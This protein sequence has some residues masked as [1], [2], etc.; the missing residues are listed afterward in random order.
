MK[1]FPAVDIKGGKVVRLLRGDYG[2][3]TVYG[4]DPV[5]AA[6]RFK[7]LG[8]GALHIVD[9]DGAKDGEPVNFCSVA[10]VKKACSLFCEIGGGI[11]SMET[12]EQYLEAGLDRVIIGTAA[13]SDTEFLRAAV[14]RYGER[15]AV[16]V[17]ARNGRV[18]VRGWLEDS[19]TDAA[20]LCERLEDMGVRTVIYTDIARDGAMLGIDAGLYG[21]LASRF[22]MDITAAGG[23][24]SLADVKALRDAGVSAAIIGKACYTGAIDLREAIAAAE[25]CDDK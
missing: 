1:L 13:I 24:S 17:D 12:V 8:A 25:G 9:L 3:M 22:K 11:R 6:L 5:E 15:I 4:D 14:D 19:D 16:G 2:K 10:A 7:A 20:E 21:R 23:V 18:S